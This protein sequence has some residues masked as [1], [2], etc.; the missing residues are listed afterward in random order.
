LV[1]WQRGYY[2]HVIRNDRT[3]DRLR[4]YIDQNPARWTD[5]PENVPA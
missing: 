1:V 5:D 4:A 2:E 3:L